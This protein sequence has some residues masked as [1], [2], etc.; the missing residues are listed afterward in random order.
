MG[1]GRG[2]MVG[3]SPHSLYC[4]ER[5]RLMVNLEYHVFRMHRSSMKIEYFNRSKYLV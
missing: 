5:I 1:S 4:F 3:L 2:R